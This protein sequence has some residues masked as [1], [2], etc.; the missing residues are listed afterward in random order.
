MTAALI[1]DGC[2][3]V[4]S[5]RAEDDDQGWI[6]VTF[7]LGPGDVPAFA[8]ITFDYDVDDDGLMQ[9]PEAKVYD[10]PAHF[11]SNRCLARW[12]AARGD[13]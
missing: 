13:A 6:T 10:P 12:A 7:D 11:C 3:D 4:L 8:S 5:T 1:C 2:S 9:T